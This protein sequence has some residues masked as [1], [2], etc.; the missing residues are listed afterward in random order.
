MAKAW[1]GSPVRDAG[2]VTIRAKGA[3]MS[4]GLQNSCGGLRPGGRTRNDRRRFRRLGLTQG[5]VLSNATGSVCMQHITPRPYF[6]GPGC[7]GVVARAFFDAV[8]TAREPNLSIKRAFAR[9][10]SPTS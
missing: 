2:H 8:T 4:R 6:E 1:R 3:R 5:S 7:R 10:R 9:Q